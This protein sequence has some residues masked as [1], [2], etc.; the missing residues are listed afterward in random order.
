MRVLAQPESI[1]L[2]QSTAR[3]YFGDVD[4][5]GKIVTVTSSG[6]MCDRSDTACLTAAHPLTVTGVL[7]DLPPNTHLAADLIVPNSSQADELTPTFR[8][9]SWLS[10]N[11]SFDYVALARGADPDKVLAKLKPVLDQIVSTNQFGMRPSEI[12]Q[13]RLTRFWDAHLT[14]DQFGGM[15]PAGSWTMVYGFSI[16][17]FL[18]MIVACFNFMNLATASHPP[19]PRNFPAQGRRCESVT[20]NHPVSRRGAADGAVIVSDRA[21]AR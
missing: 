12:E 10:T 5:L 1:V 16:I 4:P 6:I 8:D 11:G 21:R 2:S 13:Y 18:I 20:V 3:K 7:R 15:K 14:S 19:W 17:G 9:Q